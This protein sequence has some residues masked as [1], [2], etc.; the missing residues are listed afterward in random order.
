MV[1]DDDLLCVFTAQLAEQDGTAVVEVPQQEIEFGPVTSRQSYRVALLSS[2]DES[3]G[4]STATPGRTRKR[5]RQAPPVG[6]GETI[7][8]EIEDI[9]E[10]GDGVA[11]IG[12]G[13]IVFVSETD[14]GDRVTAEVTSV[15]DNFAFADVVEGPY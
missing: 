4:G 1:I 13:Y 15:R 12:P 3:G 6:E 2:G 9:G 10:Q 8:V 7:E 5:N 11:R 14:I